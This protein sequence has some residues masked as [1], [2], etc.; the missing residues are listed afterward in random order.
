MR[1]G[2]ILKKIITERRITQT[3]IA[4]TIGIGNGSLSDVLSGKF[5]GKEST[6]NGIIKCLRL[7]KDEELEVWKAWT[8]D[9]G[10][11]KAAAYFEKLDKENKKLKKILA[12]IKEL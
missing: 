2:D 9:R 4:Q 6:I 1:T 7:S 10:E 11:E 12:S 5:V 8:L 3:E